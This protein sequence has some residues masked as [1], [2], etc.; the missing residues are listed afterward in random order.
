MI[1]HRLKLGV[2]FSKVLFT[3]DLH[4]FHKRL[5]EKD[6]CRRAEHLQPLPGEQLVD[7]MNRTVVEQWNKA[8]RSA[9]PGCVVFCLGDLSFFHNEEARSVIRQLEGDKRYLVRG[10]HDKKVPDGW[11]AGYDGFVD[12]VVKDPV[13]HKEIQATVSHYPMA[14]WKESHYGTWCL[15]GHCHGRLGDRMDN[16]FDVGVETA[17]ELG[18]DRGRHPFSPYSLEELLGILGEPRSWRGDTRP[19]GH[20]HNQRT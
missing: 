7:C 6:N 17:I 10:N 19:S 20:H 16:R 1:R 9:G 4:L 15:H 11:T 13:S 8:V 3:A 5:L 2:E 12:L 14:A 18:I